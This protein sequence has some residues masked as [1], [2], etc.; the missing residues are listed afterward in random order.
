MEKQSYY[1][2]FTSNT[3]LFRKTYNCFVGW[4]FLEILAAIQFLHK[5]SDL[6]KRQVCSL[7]DLLIPVQSLLTV[8]KHNY[9]TVCMNFPL[10]LDWQR[11]Y[12]LS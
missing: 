11:E 1:S 10:S 3:I 6:S 7:R 5:M 8:L 4:A 2:R 9:V 12:V